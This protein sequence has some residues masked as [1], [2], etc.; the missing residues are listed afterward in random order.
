MSNHTL[1]ELLAVF[2][3]YDDSYEAGYEEGVLSRIENTK[4]AIRQLMADEMLALI[5]N[6]ID[7]TRRMSFYEKQ[8]DDDQLWYDRGTNDTKDQLRTKLAE[9]LGKEVI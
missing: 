1:D 2:A 6:N 9:W 7:V 8:D 4:A 3:N 5:G